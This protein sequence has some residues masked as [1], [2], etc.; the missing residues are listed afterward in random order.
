MQHTVFLGGGFKHFFIFIPYLGKWSNLTHIFQMG[1]NH[2]VQG[3][4]GEKRGDGVD[5]VHLTPK[6]KPNLWNL[7]IH[8]ISAG[9]GARVKNLETHPNFFLAS[10]ETTSMSISK[11]K[12]KAADPPTQPWKSSFTMSF[13]SMLRLFWGGIWHAPWQKLAFFL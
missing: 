2:Q 7:K 10:S 13:V 1:W 6:T 11:M 5:E 4:S 8:E 9:H 12:F 3:L